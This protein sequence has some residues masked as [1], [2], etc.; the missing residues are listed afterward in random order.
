MAVRPA[1]VSPVV[2]DGLENVYL[3]VVA[4]GYV[5]TG[6]LAL[7]FGS[8]FRIADLKVNAT[9]LDQRRDKTDVNLLPPRGKARREITGGKNFPPNE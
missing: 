5:S 7:T 1:T 3:T 8:A 2:I 9:A 4:C 6:D